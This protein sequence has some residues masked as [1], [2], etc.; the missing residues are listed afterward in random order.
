MMEVQK[1]FGSS[2]CSECYIILFRSNLFFSMDS[3]VSFFSEVGLFFI[4][5]DVY[6]VAVFL[7]LFLLFC[8]CAFDVF[9]CMHSCVKVV[10]ELQA[11]VFMRVLGIELTAEPSL[12]L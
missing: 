12:S 1:L 7:L 6:F 5:T 3:Y 10:L 4:L 8:V 11:V 9:A 2:F